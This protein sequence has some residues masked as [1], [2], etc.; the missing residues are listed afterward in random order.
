MNISLATSTSSTMQPGNLLSQ[1]STEGVTSTPHVVTQNERQ[2]FTRSPGHQ[3]SQSVHL[4]FGIEESSR[5]SNSR[6][7][8]SPFRPVT[9]QVPI[10]QSHDYLQEAVSAPTAPTIPTLSSPVKLHAPVPRRSLFKRPAQHELNDMLNSEDP[11]TRQN[12]LM[13]ELY[14][15]AQAVEVSHRRVRSRGFSLGDMSGGF[16]LANLFARPAAQE[17]PGQAPPPP[18]PRSNTVLSPPSIESVARLGSPFAEKPAAK[19]HFNTF[20]RNFSLLGLDSA[21]EIQ[22]NRP[23]NPETTAE[24]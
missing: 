16:R 22:D 1:L 6:T 9:S 18:L 12:H 2:M 19:P 17:N 7:L 8:A 3:K 4:G 10:N 21:M 5:Q 23:Q 24:L 14:G 15:P 20:P 13:R 11:F